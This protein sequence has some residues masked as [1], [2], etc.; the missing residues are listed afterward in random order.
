[1]QA[2]PMIELGAPVLGDA[3]KQAL[4]AVLDDR[5]L[6]MGE[7]VRAVR[8]R[9]RRAPRGRRRCG[10]RLGDRGAAADPRGVRH[11]TR[12]TRSSCRP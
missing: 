5:W 10:G 3:E 2:L 9:L 11:R 4:I 12:A 7:R 1:M 8:T 6:T